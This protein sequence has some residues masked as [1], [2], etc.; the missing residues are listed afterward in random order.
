MAQQTLLAIE[1]LNLEQ[2][3]T[4]MI[5][6]KILY[7]QENA[8]PGEQTIRF[9]PADI[10]D[11]II[12][13]IWNMLSLCPGTMMDS[14]ALDFAAA[15]AL[16]APNLSPRTDKPVYMPTAMSHS[17]FI[18]GSTDSETHGKHRWLEDNITDTTTSF[19]AIINL[20]LHWATI[21]YQKGGRCTLFDSMPSKA[22]SAKALVLANKLSRSMEK[23][24]HT[25]EWAISS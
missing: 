5:I 19:V 10:D 23:L 2:D 7:V 14:S 12:I 11:A 3:P 8:S 24:L 16:S 6:T 20:G 17:L 21:H 22:N 25:S 15:I 13:S 18:A 9:T 4:T 1:L